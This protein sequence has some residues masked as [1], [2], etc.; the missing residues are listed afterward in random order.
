MNKVL[1]KISFSLFFVL[2]GAFIGCSDVS[3]PIASRWTDSSIVIDGKINDWVTATTSDKRTKISGGFQNDSD[4]LY[5]L[6]RPTKQLLRQAM[7]FGFTIWFDVEGGNKKRLGI[8]F[9]IGMMNY[10]HGRFSPMEMNGQLSDILKHRLSEMLQEFDI[11]YPEED[12][13]F[14]FSKY[15]RGGIDIALNDSL[16]EAV[17]EMKIPLHKIE[18]QDIPLNISSLSSSISVGIELGEFDRSKVREQMPDRPDGGIPP[19]GMGGGNKRG[20]GTF[21]MGG[22]AQQNIALDAWFNVQLSSGHF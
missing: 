21:P 13:Q 3:T 11:V 4:Y 15:L 16:E 20:G 2:I 12:D 14:R 18:P 10:T 22:M 1:L 19:G 8:R 5:I 9:P 6:L 17:Y 7:M